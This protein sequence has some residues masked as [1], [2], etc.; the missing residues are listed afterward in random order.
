MLRGTEEQ[1]EKLF[2]EGQIW[3]GSHRGNRATTDRQEGKKG[4]PEYSLYYSAIPITQ[5]VWLSCE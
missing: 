2:P 1:G 3:V 5:T 4:S